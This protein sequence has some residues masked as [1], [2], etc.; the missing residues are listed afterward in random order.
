MI[1][2]LKGFDD[3]KNCSLVSPNRSVSGRGGIVNL[4]DIEGSKDVG[5]RVSAVG[6]ELVNL[7]DIEGSKDLGNRV[8]AVGLEGGWGGGG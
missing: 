3:K 4:L 8:S 1:S 5:N 6:L 2:V 7:L